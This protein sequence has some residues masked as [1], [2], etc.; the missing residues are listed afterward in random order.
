MQNLIDKCD[1]W[2]GLYL[3]NQVSFKLREKLKE[4]KGN[5]LELRNYLFSRQCELLLLQHMPWQVA[6]RS[7]PF[8]QNCVS[9]LRQLEIK[10]LPGAVDCWVF[11]SAS[12]ILLICERYNDSSQMDSYSKNT[13]DVRAY[14][15]RKLEELGKICGLVPGMQSKSDH[16]HYVVTLISG[17]GEDKHSD[18]SS[19][20]A[21]T[22]LKDS[23]SSPES[24][25]K[26][27]LEFSELT[28]G[29]YKHIGR[30]RE[31]RLVGKE[32]AEIYI[33]LGKYQLALS[34][35]L[36][37]EKIF[38]QEKWLTLLSNIRKKIL[39]C[40]ENLN[41]NGKVI[42]Y[43]FYLASS[44]DL[45][46]EEREVFFEKLRNLM[47]ECKS[48]DEPIRIRMNNILNLKSIR[49]NSQN[50]DLISNFD[51]NLNVQLV[52]NLV[53]ELDI[54]KMFY[55]LQFQS[56]QD[57][58]DKR[59]EILN[60]LKN[61]DVCIKLKKEGS[62]E[63]PTFNSYQDNTSVGIHCKN[64]DKVLKRFDSQFVGKDSLINQSELSFINETEFILQPG[65]QDLH[66]K[67]NTKFNGI[68]SLNEFYLFIEPNIYF[69]NNEIKQLSFEVISQKPTLELKITNEHL[70]CLNDELIAGIS[71]T[72]S[73]YLESGSNY[74]SKSTRIDFK[75]SNGLLM[76]MN[77]GL[78]SEF[79]NE[80][81]DFRLPYEL[82]PFERYEFKLI[83]FCELGEQRSSELITKKLELIVNED[84]KLNCSLLHFSPPF[85][86]TMS[87]H[88]CAIKKFIQISLVSNSQLKL[89]LD[90][91]QLECIFDDNS[92]E[93]ELKCKY[94]SN[95]SNTSIQ[96]EQILYLMW[97]I[98]VNDNASDFKLRFSLNYEPDS[99]HFKNQQVDENFKYSLD[100]TVTSYKCDFVLK[101]FCTLYTVRVEINPQAGSELIRAGNLCSLS[102]K[103]KKNL[104]LNYDKAS[105]MYE[106][107]SD[108]TVWALQGRIS[109]ILES[110]QFENEK[111][112]ELNFEVLPLVP[113]MLIRI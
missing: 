3:S 81:L 23:L 106:I 7:L 31:A 74:F 34:F 5:F 84:L 94:L 66:L 85:Y 111:D 55:N 95:Q 43:C 103:I 76:K 45:K 20:S 96:N 6:N 53:K 102:V 80:I 78:K 92:K 87:L 61:N 69:V 49:I 67:F 12:E 11:L 70:E 29:T 21:Q 89:N 1:S 68:F 39:K 27:Y 83:V 62:L 22:R 88:T 54:K 63:R 104:N 28:M 110:E 46:D 24:F 64:L 59:K 109:G 112:Y 42:T 79:K 41:D 32:L 90:Q 8:L 15:R 107:L 25:L 30:L 17:M 82:R 9:E 19:I 100:K 58:P 51:I 113:G 60:E 77:D 52:N 101:E 73:V 10:L 65:V 91:P 75:S 56:S 48:D 36:D 26:N 71:Q 93:D 47:K 35:L 105:I 99:A 14:S 37:L 4:S 97:E 2:H 18:T 44:P 38:M 86:T 98:I 13:I 108:K 40:Y 33:K 50:K 72:I 16:L 57:N